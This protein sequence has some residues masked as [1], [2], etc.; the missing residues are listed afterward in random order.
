MLGPS[1]CWQTFAHEPTM[2]SSMRVTRRVRKQEE[3]KGQRNKATGARKVEEVAMRTEVGRKGKNE[4]YA[5]RLLV[6]ES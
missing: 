3:T 2:S 1:R 5:E 6:P 4:T